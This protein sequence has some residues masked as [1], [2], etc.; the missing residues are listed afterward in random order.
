MPNRERLLY[1]SENGDR[2]SLA[3]DPDSGHIIVRH[4]ANLPSG[5]RV[6]DVGLGEFL[7]Q[8]GLGPEKQQ[9][10]HLLGSLIEEETA[11]SSQPPP[12]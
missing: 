8:N 1:A 3:Q 12:S 2:W 11:D 10:L 4:R 6:S 7:V 9:L 5:G